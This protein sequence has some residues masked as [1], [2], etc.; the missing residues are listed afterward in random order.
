M[1]TRPSAAGT[2]PSSASKN[3][4]PITGWPAS[5]S[6]S[7]VVKMRSRASARLFVGRWT[8]TVSAKFISR[9]I[10]C[11]LARGSPSPSVT[12]ARGLPSSGL[13]VKTSSV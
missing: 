1:W 8:N 13:V 3:Q 4:V 12:T 6:S 2:T 11:I 7:V 5:G 10:A 9:A